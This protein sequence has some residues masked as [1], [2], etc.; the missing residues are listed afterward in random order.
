MFCGLAQ[1]SGT[2]SVGRHL[3]SL[4]I[5]SLDAS[6]VPSARPEVEPSFQLQ[7]PLRVRS[8]PD[9]IASVLG[10]LSEQPNVPAVL[11]FSSGSRTR[12]V[13]QVSRALH[14]FGVEQY[15]LQVRLLACFPTCKRPVT[16]L[17]LL[18]CALRA[19]KG[20]RFLGVCQCRGNARA[21]S[22]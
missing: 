6:A 8:D 17:I 14:V 2:V 5:R 1:R 16:N 20:V 4:P 15:G 22:W 9:G 11:L 21:I 12:L 3:L 7:L 19:A 13:F 18:M 10:I